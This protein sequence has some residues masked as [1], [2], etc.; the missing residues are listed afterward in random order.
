MDDIKTQFV[1]RNENDVVWTKLDDDIMIIT[2]T[3]GREKV[4]KL[5]KS[6]AYLWEQC[7][8]KKTVQAL[9][10]CLCD[11]YDID[12]ATALSDA[13]AFI[14]SMKNLLTLSSQSS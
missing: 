9:S 5:N 10:K 11:K 7:D 2:T 6:A 8:G 1:F 13:I 4:L 3:E 14:I 12:E